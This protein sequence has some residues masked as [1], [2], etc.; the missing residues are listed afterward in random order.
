MADEIGL[1]VFIGDSST[2]CSVLIRS[3][4]SGGEVGQAVAETIVLLHFSHTVVLPSAWHIVVRTLAYS[5]ATLVSVLGGFHG[6]RNYCGLPFAKEASRAE[7]LRDEI[8]FTE[9]IDRLHLGHDAESLK[10][11]EEAGVFR[12]DGNHGNESAAPRAGNS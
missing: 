10:S 3:V 9:D 12:A 1:P 7:T 8:V 4:A 6:Y 2:D 5:A 11:R